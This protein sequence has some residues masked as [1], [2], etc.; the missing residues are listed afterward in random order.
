MN[1]E[2]VIL[3]YKIV[4]GVEYAYTY[5]NTI[6]LEIPKGSHTE[7]ELK[8][9]LAEKIDDPDTQELYTAIQNPPTKTSEEM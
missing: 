7:T 5:W 6:K 2:N 3:Y 8:N 4:D 1:P 9:L